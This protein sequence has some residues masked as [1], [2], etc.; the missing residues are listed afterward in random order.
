MPS[1]TTAA[2]LAMPRGSSSKTLTLGL[3]SSASLIVLIAASRSRISY[4]GV[5][6]DSIRFQTLGKAALSRP[7]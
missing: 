7:G 4:L 3:D 5:G 6:R 2:S 1:T